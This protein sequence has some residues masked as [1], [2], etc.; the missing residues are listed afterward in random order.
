MASE[1]TD[2]VY[3]IYFHFLDKGTSYTDSMNSIDI[4]FIHC[5][6]AFDNRVR[7]LSRTRDLYIFMLFH[8]L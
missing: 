4:V 2:H 1:E 8:T 6:K 3:P 5:V 7:T